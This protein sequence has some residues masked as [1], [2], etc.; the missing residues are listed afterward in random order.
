MKLVVKDIENN[1][2]NS[3]SPEILHSLEDDE[4]VL[5]SYRG[6]VI[7]LEVDDDERARKFLKE[8]LD[9]ALQQK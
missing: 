7:D 4:D 9:I 5:L 6:S 8:R 3:L 2:H 1:E